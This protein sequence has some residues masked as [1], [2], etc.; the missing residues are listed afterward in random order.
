LHG[1]IDL[2]DQFFVQGFYLLFQLGA[3]RRHFVF[4]A[5]FTAGEAGNGD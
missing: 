3:Q 2:L 1:L 4:A 5:E